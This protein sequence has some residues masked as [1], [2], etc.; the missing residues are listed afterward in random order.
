MV[1]GVHG[2]E[3]PLSGSRHLEKLACSSL[4][5][6]EALIDAETGPFGRA[7]D[8]LRIADANVGPPRWLSGRLLRALEA[9]LPAEETYMLQ[10]HYLEGVPQHV[11]GERLGIAQSSVFSRIQRAMERTRWVMGLETWEH[12]ADELRRDLGPLVTERDLRMLVAIWAARWNQSRAARMLGSN[13]STVRR[14]LI[15]VAAAL[16]VS[17]A[18]E[19]AP[20]ARDLDKVFAARAWCFGINQGHVD[21]EKLGIEM[22]S[23]DA[24]AEPEIE[25]LLPER[26]EAPLA[27]PV[28][29]FIAEHLR[30]RPAGRLARSAL[31]GR[32]EDTTRL[33]FDREQS[34]RVRAEI[35]ARGARPITVRLGVV[36]A[37]Y[38]GV[39]L[40]G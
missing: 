18:H 30:W 19:A 27:D 3:I 1:A 34:R 37:G 14:H 32:F 26:I 21:A 38:A 10:A 23:I 13:Q 28:E 9:F 16:K 31:A 6:E 11:I 12:T 25:L 4:N 7:L 29:T 22:P 5:P 20:Y 36:V 35:L 8:A 39:E 17:P 15:R 2:R 33:R 24:P 40:A